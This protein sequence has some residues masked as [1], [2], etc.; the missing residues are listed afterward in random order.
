MWLVDKHLE[1]LTCNMFVWQPANISA[2]CL[3]Y[4]CCNINF[5]N[6]IHFRHFQCTQHSVHSELEYVILCYRGFVTHLQSLQQLYAL[7]FFVPALDLAINMRLCT[8][9][10]WHC[11]VISNLPTNIPTPTQLE[12]N[13][14]EEWLRRI[15]LIKRMVWLAIR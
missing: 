15:G 14:S 11:L 2:Q 5:S 6:W 9:I 8:H 12:Q 3:T 10:C 13:P 7:E 1:I 4:G